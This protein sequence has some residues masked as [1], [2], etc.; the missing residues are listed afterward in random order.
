[1]EH[2]GD[3]M[4]ADKMAAPAPQSTASA[5]GNW[6]IHLASYRSPQGASD[7]WKTLQRQFPQLRDKTMRTSEFDPGRG[8]GTY[9]RLLAA[10]FASEAAAKDFCRPLVAKGQFCQAKGP[11]P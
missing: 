7:G 1:M 4:G 10:G 9:V 3:R 8:R 6:A 5:G 11:L 2:A